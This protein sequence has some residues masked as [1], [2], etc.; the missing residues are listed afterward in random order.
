MNEELYAGLEK[1]LSLAGGTHT[2][3]DL[4]A[5]LDRNE[6]RLWVRDGAAIVTEIQQTPQMRVCHFWLAAGDLDSVVALS[7]DI[8]E[9]AREIGCKRATLAGRRGWERVLAGEGWSPE[10]VLLGRTV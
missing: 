5:Q 6:A 4:L 10:L 1:A 8:L 2:M 9:W 7:R 3:R